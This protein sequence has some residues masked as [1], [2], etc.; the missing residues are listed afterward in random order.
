MEQYLASLDKTLQEKEKLR[1]EVM[2]GFEERMD[3][4]GAEKLSFLET[5]EQEADEIPFERVLRACLLSDIISWLISLR[6]GI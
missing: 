5:P 4:K 2:K 6:K 3:M 1:L